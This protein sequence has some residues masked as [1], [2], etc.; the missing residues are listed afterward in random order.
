[1]NLS[2]YLRGK[3]SQYFIPL[4]KKTSCEICGTTESLEVHHVYT[5]KN[6]VDDTLEEYGL[7]CL[8]DRRKK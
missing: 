6:I 3:V 5:F 8:I 4:V 2:L 1:M 7:E